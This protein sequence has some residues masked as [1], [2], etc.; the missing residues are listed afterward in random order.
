MNLLNSLKEQKRYR[1]LLHFLVVTISIFIYSLGKIKFDAMYLAVLTVF[2][3]FLGALLTQFPSIDYKNVLYILI[4]PI[5]VISGALMFYNF[6]PNLGIIFKTLS[7]VVFGIFYYRRNNRHTSSCA[8][9]C[10]CGYKRFFTH[11][12]SKKYR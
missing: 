1:Y 4:N 10:T 7:V 11:C 12:E 8:I 9:I 6:F 5:S 2:L 3:V